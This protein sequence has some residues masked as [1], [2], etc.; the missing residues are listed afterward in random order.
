[1]DLITEQAFGNIPHAL[2]SRIDA[3]FENGLRYRKMDAVYMSPTAPIG[4]A[5]SFDEFREQYRGRR[6]NIVSMMFKVDGK[7]L[8]AIILTEESRPPLRLW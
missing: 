7:D 1:V 5:K 3:V 4:N 6:T 2:R 8:H